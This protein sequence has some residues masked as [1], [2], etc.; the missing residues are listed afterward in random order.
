L[1]RQDWQLAPLFYDYPVH[2]GNRKETNK[3]C[4]QKKSFSTLKSAKIGNVG[5]NSTVQ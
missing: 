3:L 4:L 2:E 1:A 5:K